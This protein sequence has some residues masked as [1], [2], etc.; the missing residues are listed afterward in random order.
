[1]AD[2]KY[3][4]L[5]RRLPKSIP[6][7]KSAEAKW[8][9]TSILVSLSLFLFP[10]SLSFWAIWISLEGGKIMLPSSVIS[11]VFA[12]L[13]VLSFLAWIAFAVYTLRVI[14]PWYKLSTSV[15]TNKPFIDAITKEVTDSIKPLIGEVQTLV[16][17]IRQDRD[18]RNANKPK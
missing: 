12:G 10:L 5:V 2:K 15:D 1:M 7:A 11:W 3:W 4:G 14:L 13:A 6:T 16:Q 9:V 17:E 18:E 8:G